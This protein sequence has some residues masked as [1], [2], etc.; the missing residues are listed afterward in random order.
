MGEQLLETSFH[1]NVTEK[2]VVKGMF[3]RKKILE[4]EGVD[5]DGVDT[6]T[7]KAI[8]KEGVG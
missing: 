1:D 8:L 7:K 3:G 4:L 6:K 2:N 5:V